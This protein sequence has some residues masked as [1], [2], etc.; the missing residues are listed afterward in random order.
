MQADQP[1]DTRPYDRL[2]ISSLCLKGFD[3]WFVEPLLYVIQ[4]RCFGRRQLNEEVS[5]QID[6]FTDK[7]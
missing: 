1:V 7:L 4:S 3:Q 2:Y 6:S 5:K